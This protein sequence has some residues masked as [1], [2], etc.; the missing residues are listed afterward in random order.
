[1][2]SKTRS[3]STW[4]RGRTSYNSPSCANCRYWLASLARL[5]GGCLWA[6]SASPPSHP[7]P[8]TLS[9]LLP[10]HFDLLASGRNL[11]LPALCSNASISPR[12][13]RVS[14]DPG[15]LFHCNGKLTHPLLPPAS[16]CHFMLACPSPCICGPYKCCPFDSFFIVAF[17]PPFSYELNAV[18]ANKTA[19]SKKSGDMSSY[20]KCTPPSHHTHT[21]PNQ[22]PLAHDMMVWH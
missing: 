13:S 1:M 15:S 9:F 8:P 18:F 12:A 17:H 16:R 4:W 3:P 20:L 19:T 22:T 21:C 7:T 6:L 5:H 14:F 10:K 2:C 11:A